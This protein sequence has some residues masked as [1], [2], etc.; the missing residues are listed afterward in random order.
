MSDWK[1]HLINALP[2]LELRENEPL[3]PLT[4]VKIGGPAELLA[5]PKSTQELLDTI[6]VAIKAGIPI[7][8]L[9]WGANTL[10]ADRGISGLVI[11]PSS[12]ELVISDDA[13]ALQRALKQLP[14]EK[15]PARWV[16]A[17][18]D[19][20]H[21]DFSAVDFEETGERV[22]VT[23]AAGVSLPSAINQLLN[24]GVTGL[25]WFA[26]IPA[27]IGG[28]LYNN[29]HGGTKFIGDYVSSVR[30]ISTTGQLQALTN[31]QLE[32]GYDY[33][34]FHHSH[35]IIIDAAFVLYRGDVARAREAMISWAQQKA[36]QPQNS[37]G[38]IF[39]N[40]SEAD[41]RRLKLPTPSIGYLIEHVLKLKGFQ[42][43]GAMVSQKHAAFI[44]NTGSA[45]AADYLAVITEITKQAKVRCQLQLKPEIFFYGFTASELDML[46]A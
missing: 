18:D 34:R 9:G 26:R 44:E 42:V 2:Q 27:S 11:R 4:T 33:S 45:T 29:I 17:T 30:T 41:Q 36:I 20:S 16:K 23:I 32:F 5:L 1:N 37:L 24:Q 3:G 35:E 28:A 10:I 15:V 13:A 38:C 14:S 21:A 40:L 43:G 22:L 46:A 12:S 8:M 19:T 39:Q 7:T 31:D 6:D 25:Q